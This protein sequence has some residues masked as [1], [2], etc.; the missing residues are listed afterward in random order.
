MNNTLFSATHKTLVLALGLTAACASAQATP[1]LRAAFDPG[2][3]TYNLT[4]A[5]INAT[6][7]SDGDATLTNGKVLNT[8]PAH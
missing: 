5:T 3:T 7:A 4:G 8:S 2:A 1:I 6:T